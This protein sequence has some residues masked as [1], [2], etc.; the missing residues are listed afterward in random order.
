MKKER[1]GLWVLL[2]ILLISLILTLLA[3]FAMERN[4]LMRQQVN[5]S[6]LPP[7]N[8]LN[9]EHALDSAL[10]F[11]KCGELT[12]AENLLQEALRCNPS[13]IDL[14]MLLGA[15]FYRQEKYDQAEQTFRHVLRQQP[16]NAAAFNNLSETLIKL[17]RFP[18]AVTAVKQALSLEP[19]NSAILLNAACLY[20]L[21]H[22]D[23][24]ALGFLKEAMKRG[25]TPETVGQHPELV[26]LLERP[27]FMSY[28]T[29]QKNE[30]KEIKKP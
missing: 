30:Q 12:K 10:Y 4:P 3:V 13:Q 2:T 22:N 20:A 18:E 27:E 25:I 19:G 24:Q 9:A 16:Q 29:R 1:R 11:I 8:Q 14:R 7:G 26:H 23:Q 15:V 21:L 5:T 17:K 6:P 28:F